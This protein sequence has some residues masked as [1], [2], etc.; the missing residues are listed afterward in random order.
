MPV[1]LYGHGEETLSLVVSPLIN[2]QPPCGMEQRV[3]D[4]DGAVKEK[5]FIRE[6]QWD[7]FGNEV[8]HVDFTRVSADERLQ[9]EVA[10]ILRGESPGVKEGG[11]I[12]HLQHNIEIECLAIAIPEKL[13]LRIGG[14]GL[15]QSLR[16][17]NIELPQGVTL[18]T[19]PDTVV[20]HCALPVEEPEEGATGD[21]AEPAIIGRKAGEDGE[22]AEE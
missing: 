9:I 18:I 13:E 8:L 21:S 7:P 17:S 19:D 11:H 5:A 14:L 2:W 4:L 12:E 10:V 16:A 6:L 15:D 22:A 20:V 3:V 1:V